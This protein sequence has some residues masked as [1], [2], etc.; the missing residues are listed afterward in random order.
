M[1]WKS[2]MEELEI[3][4]LEIEILR[5]IGRSSRCVLMVDGGE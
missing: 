2:E 4:E 5:R 1:G 3:E